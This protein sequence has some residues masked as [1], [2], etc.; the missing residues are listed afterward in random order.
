MRWSTD[1]DHASLNLGVSTCLDEGREIVLIHL[2]IY[3]K[4]RPFLALFFVRTLAV[5]ILGI[6]ARPDWLI[7]STL[8][9]HICLV[10]V[11]TLR[12]KCCHISI[13]PLRHDRH[14]HQ[15]LLLGHLQTFRLLKLIVN[16]YHRYF[17]LCLVWASFNGEPHLSVAFL[18]IHYF[19]F[20]YLNFIDTC[21]SQ[22]TNITLKGAHV[23][24]HEF[25]DSQNFS[26][27]RYRTFPIWNIGLI[28]HHG[29]LQRA[30]CPLTLMIM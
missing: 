1:F 6:F 30:W 13:W 29:V 18:F 9:R 5:K 28:G 23:N 15:V 14:P 10:E 2:R 24:V 8:G 25:I 3:W 17:Q 16:V 26:F 12:C 21:Y 4:I 7:E 22:P 20:F 27:N 19:Q 11:V